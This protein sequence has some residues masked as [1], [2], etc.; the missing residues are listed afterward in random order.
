MMKKSLVSALLLSVIATG[1]LNLEYGIKDVVA[2]AIINIVICIGLV[3]VN[4]IENKNSLI[5][6]EEKNNNNKQCLEAMKSIVNEIIETRDTTIKKNDESFERINSSIMMIKETIITNSNNSK[7]SMDE[8]SGKLKNVEKVAIENISNIITSNKEIQNEINIAS[9]KNQDIIEKLKGTIVSELKDNSINIIN[10]FNS[11]KTSIDRISE[12]LN[13]T[14]DTIIENFSNI[15]KSNKEIIKES[16]TIANK[17]EENINIL[18][19]AVVRQLEENSESIIE[20]MYE[21]KES[22]EDMQSEVKNTKNIIKD[23]IS[24]LVDSNKDIVIQYKEIQGEMFKELNVLTD[25][26]KSI[27]ELLKSNYK[28]LNTLIE[29]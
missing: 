10:G 19:D 14:K 20:R 21:S 15:I 26:N 11:S 6:E 9:S 1:A 4:I 13:N 17:N 5:L 29:N 18:K 16:K 7:N 28:V 23:N 2:L 12:E 3:V 8:I 27:L 22:I 25:K 24:D